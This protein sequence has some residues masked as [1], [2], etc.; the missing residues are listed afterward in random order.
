VQNVVDGVECLLIFCLLEV[1][2][3]QSVEEKSDCCLFMLCG[4]VGSVRNIYV[5]ESVLSVNERFS[6]CWWMCG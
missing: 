5:S 4:M 1:G 6:C 2:V 3:V